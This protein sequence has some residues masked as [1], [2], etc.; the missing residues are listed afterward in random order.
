MRKVLHLIGTLTDEDVEWL[1]ANGETRF[2][3]RNT[4]V[5]Q[6]GKSI[7]ALL[8]LLEGKLSVR[9][10]GSDREVASL[11]PGEVLG[12]MSF[13]DARPPSAS[14]VAVQDSHLLIVTRAVLTRRLNHNDAFAAR[15]YRGL[16]VFLADRLR[17]TTAYL[18]Y[19]AWEEDARAQAEAI[20]EG[21]FDDIT[22]AA[23]RFDDMLRRLRMADGSF[24]VG[25]RQES[26]SS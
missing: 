16:A 10:A 3:P 15:F 21:S 12:E 1:A 22:L 20:D 25:S 24:G 14:V 18:G 5:I 19:G 11:Y 4:T 8:M 17:T 13:V 7:E 23:R 9:L 2:V 6:Q 26:A